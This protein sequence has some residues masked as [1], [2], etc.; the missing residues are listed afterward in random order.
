MI[1][2]LREGSYFPDWLLQPRRR[3][4]KALLSVVAESYLA[5][6]STRRVDHLVKTLGING[7][8]KSQVSEMAK[9]LDEAVE[10]FRCRPL[11]G[12][13]PYVW[14]DAQ[15]QKSRE[16]GRV[17]N[18]STVLGIGV[19]IDGLRDVLGVDV[20]TKEDEA[21]WTAFLR[22]LKDRGLTDVSLVISDSHRGLK[23]AI[24]KVFPGSSW[25]RC[26][27]HFM[28][29]LLSR[30]PKSA[31]GLVATMMRTI[32]AQPDEDSVRTQHEHISDQLMSKFP[33]AATLLIDAK[34]EILA[35]TSYP[36]E[37][38]RQ[39][40][41]NNPLERLNR[42]VRRRTDVVGIFPNRDSVIRLVGAVL[43]EQNDEWQVSRRYMSSESLA[44][45]YL[46]AV[47]SDASNPNEEVIPALVGA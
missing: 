46:M 22:D 25:Q 26:R 6:V 18:I 7:I 20:F 11:D 28:R 33:E 39:I 23:E 8:S 31:Q 15:A 45:T 35:F 37:H 43:A 1:P 9:S 24:A 16:G 36:K 5:G 32:F 13:Y 12:R 3:A 17:V 40:W 34:E 41:S 21:G 19:N 30:V 47:D 10:D 42:E 29:N 38:W 4:Q 44:K 27:T 14:I 2:K